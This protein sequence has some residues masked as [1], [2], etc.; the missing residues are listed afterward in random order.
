MAMDAAHPDAAPEPTRASVDRI[1]IIG[2]MGSGK[3]TVA[4]LVGDQLSLPVIDS[5][6]WIEA[7]IGTSG[8]MIAAEIGVV[9]LHRL[10]AEMLR[11][12]IESPA[13]FVVTPAASVVDDSVS[14]DLL[15][16]LPLVA[17]LDLDAEIGY[18]RAVRG[19]HRRLLTRTEYRK[20]HV[21]RRPHFTAVAHLRLSAERSPTVLADE[22]VQAAAGSAR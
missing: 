17:W 22:V 11:Q 8:A 7:T 12:T 6:S 10:E 5:D 21:Q 16:A 2:S 20:L 19:S 1:A 14:R 15:A 13:S 18:E 4:R 9:E 3:S